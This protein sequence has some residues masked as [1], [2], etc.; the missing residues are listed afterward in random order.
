MKRVL[1]SN[2]LFDALGASKVEWGEPDAEGFYTPA[3]YADTTEATLR[4]ARDNLL[5]VMQDA[6][7]YGRER[8]RIEDA[9]DAMVRAAL[10]QPAVQPEGGPE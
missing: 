7:L 5:R 4:A 10:Q 8:Q 2:E 9:A 3:V 1:M 6:R